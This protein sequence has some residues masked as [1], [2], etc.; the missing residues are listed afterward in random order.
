[1]RW[2]SK[3]TSAHVPC[4]S[5]SLSTGHGLL[6]EED[7][8]PEEAG[9]PTSELFFATFFIMLNMSPFTAHTGLSQSASPLAPGAAASLDDPPM[10]FVRT[11]TPVPPLAA[12]TRASVHSC[13]D[14]QEKKRERKTRPE[15]T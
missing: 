14:V 4:P 7:D 11:G 3:R 2:I 10:G 5:S 8:A 6:A 15:K 9:V 13:C 1:M 12:A